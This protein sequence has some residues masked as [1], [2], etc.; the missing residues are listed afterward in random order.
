M[1]AV[2]ESL[3]NSGAADP[4]GRA[5]G[6]RHFANL[7]SWFEAQ[8][9]HSPAAPAVRCEAQ[10]LT[11]ADLNVRANI[12][13]H[14]L[15][16]MGVGADTLVGL[17]LDRSL[18]PVVAMLGILKSGAAYLPI[19]V[20]SPA[21]RIRFVLEDAQPRVI[22][23]I[24]ALVDEL[25]R[26]ATTLCIDT[27]DWQDEEDSANPKHGDDPE[28]LA[29]VIYTSGSTGEPKG[30]LITHRN[31]V[32]LFETTAALF[33][34]RGED[35]WSVFHSFAFDFSVWELWGALLHGA[36]AVLVPHTIAREPRAFRE[37]LAQ[38]RISVLCQTP[39]AFYPLIEADAAADPVP[40]LALRYVIFGGEALDPRRLRPWFERH[41]DA[42]RLI[43]MYGIT[44][45][46]VH[47]TYHAILRDELSTAS[48]IGAPLPDLRI[49]LLDEDRVPVAP[50]QTGELYI[51]G[52]GVARGYLKRPGFD[53]GAIFIRPV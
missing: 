5:L 27:L 34:F 48:V 1:I 11:Y 4:S 33:E 16:R 51:G 25:P 36:Q 39:S 22:V 40:G 30:A 31:V 37:F 14:R 47:A 6:V 8:A 35:V 43:N 15:M 19:D 23:T 10:Q 41:G 49:Y 13:A 21:N 20:G 42:P 7:H 26:D 12:I 45:T 9:A 50:G 17:Y 38:E 3:R 44:E 28:N 2:P 24:T 53:C 32:R 29:Y 46:T 18:E 52:P